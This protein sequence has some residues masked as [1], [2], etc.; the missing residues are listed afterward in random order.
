MKLFT[1]SILYLLGLE[2]AGLLGDLLD[3]GLSAVE[4][5]LHA[6]HEPAPRRGTLLLRHL[7]NVIGYLLATSN[8]HRI[9][10]VRCAERTNN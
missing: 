8:L 1:L 10:N 6:R 7:R 3:D 5:L 2:I 9:R 4:A